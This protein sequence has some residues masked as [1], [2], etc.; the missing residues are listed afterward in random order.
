[1]ASWFSTLLGLGLMGVGLW[2]FFTG[3]QNHKLAQ[4]G[5]NGELSLVH[6]LT[7]AV[8]LAAAL[9]GNRAAKLTCLALGLAYGALAGAG[10]AN[11]L[12]ITERLNLNRP[13]HMA[14]AVIAVICLFVGVT[15][16]SD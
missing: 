9:A 4:F 11:V 5:V 10:F 3:P 14:N 12:V 7:G 2:G 15:S 1:M 13:D 6:L 16:R 8:S